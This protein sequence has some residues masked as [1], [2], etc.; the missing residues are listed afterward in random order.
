MN[1]LKNIFAR[2][3][4][5]WA[6]ISFVGTF[7]VIFLPSMGA[8]LFKN[9]YKGQI[10]FMKVSKIWMTTWL[11]MIGCPPTIHGR[12]NFKPGKNY[13]V[14]FNHNALLDPTIS[15]PFIPGANKTIAKASFSKVPVFG[16]FYGRGSVLID[17][18]N[19]K[20]RRKSFDGMKKVLQA[21]MHICIYPEGTRNRTNEPLK[22]FH[23]GA[24][25]LAVDT[26]KEIIPGII[27]G[28]KKALPINRSFYLLPTGL[29]LYFLP[30]IS[31]ENKTAAELRQEVFDVMKEAFLTKSKS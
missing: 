27:V 8:Y 1:F 25:K 19:D 2:F 30:A 20:S 7:F 4:A 26:N 5:F 11:W 28:T 18:K 24:F 10:Y 29:D 13:I 21:G 12:E 3:W 14:T 15:A 31:S 23:D 6:L 22:A 9:E 16:W 17:R